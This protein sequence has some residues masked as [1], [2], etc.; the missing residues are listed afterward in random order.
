[1]HKNIIPGIKPRW[2]NEKKKGRWERTEESMGRMGTRGGGEGKA[3]ARERARTGKA[4]MRCCHGCDGGADEMLKWASSILAASDASPSLR[5][6][7]KAHNQHHTTQH[8]TTQPKRT[9]QSPCSC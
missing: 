6:L 9:P 1:M 4:R 8:I 3:G 5:L 2:K 7:H